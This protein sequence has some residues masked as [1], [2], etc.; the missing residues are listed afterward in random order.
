[1]LQ[2]IYLVCGIPGS[3]KTFVCKQLA[4]RFSYVPHDEHISNQKGE[5]P[6]YRHKMALL[7]AARNEGKPVI[8]ECPFMISV[9][10]EELRQAGA[11]VHPIFVLE[12]K[13]VIKK[14]YEQRE[15]RPIPQ[16]HLT[17]VDS[18]M[19]TARKYAE[20]SGSSQNVLNYFQHQGLILKPMAARFPPFRIVK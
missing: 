2:P 12:P 9:M 10:I 14:R 8:G 6:I 13:E 18:I 3:G 19:G 20:F 16:Q 11:I 4:S 17:R 7:S 5:S 1:M 15:G